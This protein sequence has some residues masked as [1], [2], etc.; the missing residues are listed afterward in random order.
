MGSL[1][2]RIALCSLFKL[3][4]LQHILYSHL[5]KLISTISLVCD[6]PLVV[7]TFSSK[8]VCDL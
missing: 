4:I 3:D 1:D 5:V 6:L 7:S 2:T 8:S